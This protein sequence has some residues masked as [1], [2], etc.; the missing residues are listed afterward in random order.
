M[1]FGAVIKEIS[2]KPTVSRIIYSDGSND[3][4]SLSG[5]GMK[6]KQPKNG[7]IEYELVSSPFPVKRYKGRVWPL[8]SPV[9]CYGFPD[10]VYGYYQNV[11]FLSEFVLE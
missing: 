1:Y 8:P 2:N 10:E 5:Y 7:K 4:S 6:I 3:L 11:G 9:K